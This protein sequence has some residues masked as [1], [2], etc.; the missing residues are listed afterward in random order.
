MTQLHA[1]KL[2]HTLLLAHILFSQPRCCV[3]VRLY[4]NAWTGRPAQ[5]SPWHRR[6]RPGPPA[7]SL[8]PPVSPPLRPAPP[9]TS[10]DF[11]GDKL[12]LRGRS[13][14]R[15]LG[16]S[17]TLSREKTLPRSLCLQSFSES[18]TSRACCL[19]AVKIGCALL[20]VVVPPRV[21]GIIWNANKGRCRAIIIIMDQ[22]VDSFFQ[23][24]SSLFCRTTWRR[25]HTTFFSP[26][27]T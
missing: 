20:T 14:S 5:V 22:S 23:S 27:A 17:E 24:G 4:W 12:H 1:A 8:A 25:L 26:L 7:R 15:D 19:I 11:Q 16:V 3:G 21:V 6:P 10:A 18:C 2:L 9:V 13:S